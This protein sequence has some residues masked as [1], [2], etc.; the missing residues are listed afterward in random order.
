AVGVLLVVA[1]AAVYVLRM[2]G[3]GMDLWAAQGAEGAA[4][5][6]ARAELTFTWHMALVSLG[7]AGIAAVLR[8]RWTAAL[9]VLAL[10]ALL[11]FAVLLRHD[12]DRAHP[13][14]PP[15]PPAE[16]VPCFSGSGR[17]D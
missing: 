10:L 4:D 17:C 12:W 1:V 9:Q 15:S 16:Y 5:R 11:G 2:F 13:T 3:F 8:A 7:L 6:T 14:P